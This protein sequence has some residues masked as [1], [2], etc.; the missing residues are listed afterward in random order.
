MS[1]EANIFINTLLGVFKK[2]ESGLSEQD[3]EKKGVENAMKELKEFLGPVARKHLGDRQKL[4]TNITLANISQSFNL[5]QRSGI[6]N[7]QDE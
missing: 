2:A 4:V 7:F 6:N 3:M 5:W 1:G